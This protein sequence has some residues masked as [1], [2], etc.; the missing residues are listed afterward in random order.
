MLL[1]GL[2]MIVLLFTLGCPGGGGGTGTS[3]TSG[4]QTA[5]TPEPPSDKPA[6]TVTPD[7]PEPLD[8]SGTDVMELLDA[9]EELDQDVDELED[10]IGF[11]YRAQI[12]EVIEWHISELA[13]GD[14]DTYVM[15]IDYGGYEIKGFGGDGMVKLDV[16]VYGEDAEDDE[17]TLDSDV[18]EDAK[19]WAI[20]EVNDDQE[21]TIKFVV[22]ELGR[23]VDKAVYCWFLYED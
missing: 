19:P 7:E 22:D 20:F 21:I 9:W 12:N 6:E 1:A 2:A 8:M 13:E 23:R 18:M 3:S 14:T 17:D 11:D 16:Y 5:Q 15:D 4:T 10:W